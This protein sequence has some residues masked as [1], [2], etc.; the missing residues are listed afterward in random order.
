M[1]LRDPPRVVAVA[2]VLAAVCVLVPLAFIGALFAGIV[3]IRRNR[4]VEGATVIALG[5]ACT[6]IGLVAF[7]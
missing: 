3:L 2:Y 4:P 7:R 6:A 1:P 5:A